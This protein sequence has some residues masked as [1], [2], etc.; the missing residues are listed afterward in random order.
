MI[1]VKLVKAKPPKKWTME[2]YE[3]GKK[4][5]STSFGANGMSDYTLHKDLKRKKLYLARH[6]KRENWND[7]Y[8]AGALSRWI[9]WNKTTLKDSLLS[10]LKKFKFKTK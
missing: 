9:L 3:N 8:S 4:I 6:K 5:K 2:F 7:P 1:E 10:Y